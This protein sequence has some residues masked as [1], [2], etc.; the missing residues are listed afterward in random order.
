[1]EIQI[2]ISGRKT[3]VYKLRGVY[4]NAK[5]SNRNSL[6]QGEQKWGKEWTPKI[7]SN[8]NACVSQKK[9]KLHLEMK[10]LKSEIKHQRTKI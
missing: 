2:L 5:S 7:Y 9:L 3:F 4:T 6:K 1:M 10:H 8:F